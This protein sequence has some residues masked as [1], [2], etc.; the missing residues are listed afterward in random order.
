ME[1]ITVE[2]YLTL[3]MKREPD[4]YKEEKKAALEDVGDAEIGAT[5]QEG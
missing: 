4:R 5:E 3:T 2:L 1:S